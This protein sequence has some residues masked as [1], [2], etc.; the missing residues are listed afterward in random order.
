[1]ASHEEGDSTDDHNNHRNS[2]EADVTMSNDDKPRARP[3]SYAVAA[4]V[5]DDEGRL[6][7]SQ[8]TDISPA[9]HRAPI[10]PKPNVNGE[11]EPRIKVEEDPNDRN[12]QEI[13]TGTH[14]GG[15]TKGDSQFKDTYKIMSRY[16]DRRFTVG[17]GSQVIA[18][19]RFEQVKD[20]HTLSERSLLNEKSHKDTTEANKLETEPAHKSSTPTDTGR[21]EDIQ[22]QMQGAGA[23]LDLPVPGTQAMGPGKESSSDA[24]SSGKANK[25][26]KR[27]RIV[28]KTMEDWHKRENRKNEAKRKILFD[29]PSPAPQDPAKRRKTSKGSAMVDKKLRHLVSAQSSNDTVEAP[30]AQ[31]SQ[32]E[33]NEPPNDTQPDE[34][35]VAREA[36]A[37]KRDI[38]RLKIAS[39]SFM[40]RCR[41]VDESDLANTRWKLKGIKS[42]L[43]SH[44]L[45]GCHWMLGKEFGDDRGG[46]N[47]DDMGLGKTIQALVCIALNRP[48]KGEPKPT[49]VVVPANAVSQWLSEIPK[50]LE[51]DDDFTFTQFQA[52]KGENKRNLEKHNII[53]V[54]YDE[55]QLNYL[56]TEKHQYINSPGCTDEEKHEIQDKDL[57]MLFKMSFFRV[58]LDEAHNIKNHLTRRFIA[59]RELQAKHRWAMTGT[60]L[61][62][63]VDEL[64]PYLD[65]LRVSWLPTKNEIRQRMNNLK[66]PNND[67][68]LAAIIDTI[69][70][71]RKQH[72]KLAGKESW[73]AKPKHVEHKWIDHSEEERVIYRFIEERFQEMVTRLLER[74]K[75]EGKSRNSYSISL[76]LVLLMEL[77]QA[78]AH[79]FLLESVMKVKMC[80][81]DVRKMQDKLKGLG[82][83][84][85]F[86]QLKLYRDEGARNNFGASAFGS[87]LNIDPL[88]DILLDEKTDFVCHVCQGELTEP[89]TNIDEVAAAKEEGR[90]RA[91]C[92]TCKR[93]LE[94]WKPAQI[95][96]STSSQTV[97][98]ESPNQPSPEELA[99]LAKFGMTPQKIAAMKALEQQKQRYEDLQACNKEGRDGKK[100]GNDY[101]NVQPRAKSTTTMFLKALDQNYP[102]PMT[103]SAKTAMV[104][105]TVNDWL[106]DAPDDKIIIFTQFVQLGQILGRMLQAEGV[107]F[108]Y[109]FGEMTK[110]QKETAIETF[111][112]VDE[113]KVMIVSLKCGSVA[114]NLQCANRVIMVDPWWN[115]SI[116]N[117]AVGRV[118][119]MGQE[120]ETYIQHILVRKTAD[121]RIYRMQ[122]D[123]KDKIGQA[124]RCQDFVKMIGNAAE[125][126]NGNSVVEA[127]TKT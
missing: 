99:V 111:K 107:P 78:T 109:Y 22:Y 104:K 113:V 54:S 76:F 108:L 56:S 69:M 13:A 35:S 6:F 21:L 32:D 30:K 127:H 2:D 124:M 119:R 82:T 64:W 91:K 37:E 20:S 42:T 61:Q 47:A 16:A 95:P 57:G 89:Q 80:D 97:E 105:A 25:Q 121:E 70:L 62:N 125:D 40:G 103:P 50:H 7:V 1:M 92:P 101:Q 33:A 98:Q 51:D 58:V 34:Q 28:A 71:S 24:I 85:V 45:M 18:N 106:R 120:K 46:I 27:R 38:N 72:D 100:L 23:G 29:K 49:L 66:D 9:P 81:E 60:P 55:V 17:R 118:F 77:R 74:A 94:K 39:Q 88:L 114:L 8:H 110:K 67:K 83:T 116:E 93:V 112:G 31:Q 73:P 117:Q 12:T 59:C 102:Q 15:N 14:P 63:G 96:G 75:E 123:K 65:F 10:E 26:P 11:L 126:D 122:Q 36:K 3:R 86:Q 19:N 48:K 43:T 79:P 4:N 53:L 115:D 84:P 52:K 87:Q 68:Q 41:A 5:E 90:Y 44:Q